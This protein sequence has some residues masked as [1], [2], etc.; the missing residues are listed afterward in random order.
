ML[1]FFIKLNNIF[2][3]PATSF[4]GAVGYTVVVSK[5]F[6]VSSITAIL[7]PVLYAGSKP[8]TVKFLIGAPSNNCFAF[9]QIL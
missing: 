8:I 6:P 1:C 5:T 4:W 7:Q 3:A 2:L 9:F